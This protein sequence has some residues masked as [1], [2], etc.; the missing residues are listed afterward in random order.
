MV[1]NW[2]CISAIV[3]WCR[4]GD[5]ENKLSGPDLGFVF[6]FRMKTHKTIS[7]EIKSTSTSTRCLY[8]DI[9]NRTEQTRYN[10]YNPI[11]SLMTLAAPWRPRLFL[12]REIHLGIHG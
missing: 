6:C 12:A 11:V 1:S 5:E 10:L 3:V 2:S 8:T 4:V 7:W 9:Q